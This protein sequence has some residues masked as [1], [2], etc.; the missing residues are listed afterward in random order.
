MNLINKSNTDKTEVSLAVLI[1]TIGSGFFMFSSDFVGTF[2][3]LDSIISDFDI[4]QDQIQWITL[5]YIVI[6]IAFAVFSGDLGDNYGHKMIFQ[7]GIVVFI[8]GSFLC[9]FS[10]SIIFLLLSRVI[11]AMGV[12]LIIPTGLG[13]LTHLTPKE[14][15]G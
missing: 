9:F 8:L 5:T 14:K 2:F 7:I 10:N 1:L 11:L 4:Q 13:I 6:V 12:S 15:R 3:L